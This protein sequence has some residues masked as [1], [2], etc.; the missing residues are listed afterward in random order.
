MILKNVIE[1]PSQNFSNRPENSSV[2]TIIIHHT[3]MDSAQAALDRL[4]DP[5]AKVS[6]HYLIDIDG[7][8]YRLVPDEKKAWHA[9]ISYW[10]GREQMNNY[11]VGIELDNKGS[12]PFPSSQIES[13]LKLCKHLVAI[14]PIEAQNIIGHFDIAPDRKDDPNEYFDWKLLADNSLGLFPIVEID[15]NIEL[16]K[17]GDQ[18]S[19]VLNLTKRLA[20]YGY[21]IEQQELFDTKIQEVVIAFKRHFAQET[22]TNPAWDVLSDARLNK[23][24]TMV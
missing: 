12:D 8:I 14:Y 7:N 9:G 4:C 5:E 1:C 10:R 3:N 2:D 22:F 21:K 24:L 16:L 23:L 20:E 18:S 13:L 6:S 19:A 11:S 17:L 15:K